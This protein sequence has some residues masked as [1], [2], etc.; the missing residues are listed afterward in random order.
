MVES[1]CGSSIYLARW[2]IFYHGQ[3]LVP[4]Q[5]LFKSFDPAVVSI[6]I[7]ASL[8]KMIYLVFAMCRAEYCPS[9]D[10][11]QIILRPRKIEVNYIFL[12]TWL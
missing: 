6:C 4:G 3:D 10:C 12:Y 8:V 5:D 11:G 2:P 7:I 9:E 1:L